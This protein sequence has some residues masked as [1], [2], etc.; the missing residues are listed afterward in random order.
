MEMSATPG[1]TN[2]YKQI[3][4]FAPRYAD[5]KVSHD[6]LTGNF[7]LLSLNGGT[8]WLNAADSWHLMRTF[9]G[10][11]DFQGNY[12]NVVHNPDFISGKS[13][14]SQYKRVFY[15]DEATAPDNFTVI[16]NFEIASYVPMKP[17]YDTYDFEDKGKKVTLEVNGVKHN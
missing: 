16:H 12:E 15:D 11:V 10:I 9:E 4:G 13:D 5:Y 3:F 8:P 1:T 14:F 7:R 6:Q 2:A 17:L